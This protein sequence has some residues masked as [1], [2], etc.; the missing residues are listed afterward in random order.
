M[1]VGF[2]MLLYTKLSNVLLK[3]ALFYTV[4]VLFI[5][6]FGAFEFITTVEEA[7]EFHPLFGL[8]ATVA[9]IFSGRTVK[10]FSNLR[11]TLGPGG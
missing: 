7:K 3:E 1:S 4:I 2:M 5:A 8:G 10:Y 9:L 11:K 6:F